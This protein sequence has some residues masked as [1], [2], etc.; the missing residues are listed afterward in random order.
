MQ[1]Q[2]D[3][4]ELAGTLLVKKD[5][6]ITDAQQGD[7]VAFRKLIEK[8]SPRVYSIA[9]QIT[10]N[11][12][13]AQ[14]IA[15]EI[16]IKLYGTLHKFSHKYRFTTWLYRMAVN[17]AI[18]YQRK[19]SSRRD[20]PLEEIENMSVI[21]DSHNSPEALHERNELKGI[22]SRLS[23]LLTERQRKVFILRDLQSFSTP[24]VARILNCSQITVR[25]HL[26]SARARIKTALK[27]YYPEFEAGNHLRKGG[28]K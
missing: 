25:V 1:L 14:D 5:D 7:L 11:S 6:L 19:H 9:Y 17:T 10:G 21:D 2:A 8:H 16:F 18:D 27:Q 4:P 12:A 20:F 24:E 23:E 13:D 3:Y 28:Y 22:I 26:A 15:Q